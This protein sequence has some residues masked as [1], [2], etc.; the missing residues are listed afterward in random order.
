MLIAMGACK[1]QPN[2]EIQQGRTLSVPYP[3]VQ[4]VGD[5]PTLTCLALME[6]NIDGSADS[7]LTSGIEGKVTSGQNGA[8]LTIGNDATVRLLSDAGARVGGTAATF[9]VIINDSTQLV[10]SFFDG[11]S[12]N[13]LVINKS[14]GLAIWSK[15][16]STFPVY[17]APTGSASYMAC[18]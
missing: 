15:I 5:K 17:D 18:R 12:M 10:A 11:Q 9:N 13:S 16:R 7:S 6:A 3:P 14:N 2:T 4:G 1:P 8:T